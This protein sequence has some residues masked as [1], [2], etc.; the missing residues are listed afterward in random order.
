[1]KKSEW[2][3]HEES[4]WHCLA[5]NG[6][7]GKNKAAIRIEKFLAD[8][9]SNVWIHLRSTRFLNSIERLDLALKILVRSD[10]RRDERGENELKKEFRVIL[11]GI[12]DRDVKRNVIRY[13]AENSLFKSFS[14]ER[15]AIDLYMSGQLRKS[16]I[17][18]A[19]AFK[20][21]DLDQVSL[22]VWTQLVGQLSAYEQRLHL[23]QIIDVVRIQE[24]VNLFSAAM[25]LSVMCGCI[26]LVAAYFLHPIEGLLSR[27][28]Y[29]L[30]FNRMPL[31]ASIEQ[32][33]L[34]SID[35]IAPQKLQER[36]FRWLFQYGL[37]LQKRASVEDALSIFSAV[38]KMD[39][40]LAQLAQPLWEALVVWSNRKPR[41]HNSGI[42]RAELITI[43]ITKADKAI[44][45]FFSGWN[46]ALGHIP[47]WLLINVLKEHG[48]GVVILRDPTNSWFMGD[49][50]QL[51][52]K[53]AHEVECIRN[54]CSVH[55]QPIIFIGSSVTG[56]SAME[57]GV[58]FSPAA[59]I[60]FA[61]PLKA[62]R[63]KD[64]NGELWATKKGRKQDLRQC[65][66]ERK[67]PDTLLC[68][69]RLEKQHTPLFY[70][71][72]QD[73]ATDAKNALI[74]AG[75]DNCTSIGFLGVMTHAVSNYSIPNGM[76]VDLLQN[77]SD[78]NTGF[79]A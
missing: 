54:R 60:N 50:G 65:L 21:K 31:D 16:A 34:T 17:A 52:C 68:L 9:P 2:L 11:S 76:L 64:K 18:F 45:I 74:Y 33:I 47:D 25:T 55:E 4:Q 49:A 15:T 5:Q 3:D 29:L 13:L 67:F 75:H 39:P 63:S 51:N 77:I 53:W 57:Y 23:I 24:N 66:L 79:G 19:M 8:H 73:N 27:W 59:I 42:S 36:D 7:D 46:G 38:C 14:L 72:G 12:H 28:E 1:M 70:L 22:T 35:Q 10:I 37:I 58:R 20:G 62:L 43:E 78:L 71:Y 69:R 41:W 32:K 26:D 40:G 6:L 61:G 48:Y 44:C 30:W 56:L